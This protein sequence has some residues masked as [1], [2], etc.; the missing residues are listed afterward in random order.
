MTRTITEAHL[1]DSITDALQYVSYYHTPDF[2]QAMVR[3]YEVEQSASAR[4]AIRQIL[5]NSR[6]AA[7]GH[8]P[9]CQDTG[10]ANVFLKVGVQ[11][12]IDWQRAPQEL[13]DEA[14][15]RAY[16]FAA[17]PLRASIVADPLGARRNT[18][19]NT[20]AMIQ[21]ELV[22]GDKVSVTVSAKGGGSENKTKFT[23]LNPSDSVAD[24]VVDTVSKLGAGWCP[25]GIIGLGVGGSVDKAMA[26]AKEALN[27]PLDMTDLQARGAQSAEEELRLELY[28][29]INALGIGAQGLGGLVTALDVKVNSFP[30]H[31]ASL[32]VALIP[33][34]AATRH[35]HFTLDGS[36]PAQF[37]PP[38]LSLWPDLGDAGMVDGRRVDLDALDDTLLHSLSPGD[39][40]LLSGTLYTGRDAAHRRMLDDLAKGTPLPVDL[41]GRAIYYVGPV[42]AVGDEVIGPAGPTTSTRMDKFTEPLLQ[43]SGLKMMIGKAE[44]GA[45][46]IAAIKDHGAVYLIAV[47]GAAYLVSKA[48][49]SARPVAYQDLGMEAIYEIEVKDMPVTVAVDTQGASIHTSGPRQWARS[50]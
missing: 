38:D 19:D 41:K 9:I 21:T 48:I 18:R 13:I 44:R 2:V 1:I 24:W 28:E 46:A 20:P 43:A 33:N 47:G 32:P 15:R 5:I 17:N 30:T 29:R 35:V 27:D 4:N 7:I 26:M 6:M 3:A 11:A 16:D 40:L 49:Q 39:T 22:A 34:C 31:A 23:V 12:P 45:Q 8:R 10:S 36:G 42:D 14:T 25:P 50:R 37:T